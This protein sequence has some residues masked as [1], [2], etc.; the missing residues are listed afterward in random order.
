MSPDRTDLAA[1][2]IRRYPDAAM[3]TPRADG[4]AHTARV[5]LGVADGRIQ[6]SGGPGLVRTRHVR[7]EPRCSRFVSGPAPHWLGLETRASI[8][9]GPDAPPRLMALMRAR[10]ADATPTGMVLGHNDELG[11]DRLYA[12][13]EYLDHVR[14]DQRLVFDFEILRAYGNWD[15]G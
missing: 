13:Q 8:L 3:V 7:R 15:L 12:E 10:H 11:T 5:E 4:S 1:G 9:D 2:F 14:A 6:T